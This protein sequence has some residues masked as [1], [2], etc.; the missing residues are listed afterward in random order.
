MTKETAKMTVY[1]PTGTR[2]PIP[3]HEVATLM[4][5]VRIGKLHH[6]SSLLPSSLSSLLSQFFPTGL[7]AL[8]QFDRDLLIYQFH[9]KRSDSLFFFNSLPFDPSGQRIE[10][11]KTKK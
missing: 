1:Q 3:Q 10:R 2:R 5:I 6:T 11:R 9:Q 8:R 4:L 7:M